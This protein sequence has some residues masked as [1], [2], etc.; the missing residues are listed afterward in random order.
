MFKATLHEFWKAEQTSLAQK[1]WRSVYRGTLRSFQ[2]G[3][4]KHLP[5]NPTYD[6]YRPWAR[7]L[8]RQKDGRQYFEP[9]IPVL[10]VG[11]SRFQ[12]WWFLSPQKVAS[13]APN[14]AQPHALP[15]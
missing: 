12:R 5:S 2:T 11:C 13:D 7:I 3:K 14:K 1:R 4:K 15:Q 10:E 9:W 6:F 8:Q